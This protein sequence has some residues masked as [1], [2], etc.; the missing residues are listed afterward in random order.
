MV[1]RSVRVF[2]RNA[3]E[4]NGVLTVLEAAEVGLALPEADSIWVEAECAGSVINDL[5]EI[6][7]RRN[8]V[9]DEDGADLRFGA[10]GVKSIPGRRGVHRKRNC[11]LYGDRLRNRIDVE[12]NRE[13]LRSGS[14]N[15]DS[16]AGVQCKTGRGRFHRVRPWGQSGGCEMAL[17]VR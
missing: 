15:G 10:C 13:I 17:G 9:L 16:Q 3:V 14:C 5:G 12:R 7:D 2:E 6:R 8:K 11:L 4:G 1:G